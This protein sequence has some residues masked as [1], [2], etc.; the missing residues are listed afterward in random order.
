[1]KR[2]A[3]PW[4]ARTLAWLALLLMLLAPGVAC[5]EEATINEFRAASAEGF[6]TGIQAIFG[7][8]IDGLFAVYT[9]D[10][11]SSSSSSSGSGGSSSSSQTSS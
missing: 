9:P 2:R 3:Y 11:E 4:T 5:D 7:A 10:D 8:F 6:S 1:M